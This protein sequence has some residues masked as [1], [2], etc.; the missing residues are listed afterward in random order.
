MYSIYLW[1][2]RAVSINM[3]NIKCVVQQT[4]NFRN[5]SRNVCLFLFDKLQSFSS[6]PQ[7]VQERNV[8]Q[9]SA[10]VVCISLF[11]GTI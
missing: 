11:E 4:I 1:F 7:S 10:L 3:S 8:N 9:P 5:T 2:Y 6:I